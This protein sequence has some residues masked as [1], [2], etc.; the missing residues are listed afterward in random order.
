[1]PLA[2]KTLAWF[3]IS[4]QINPENKDLPFE[5]PLS[6]HKTRQ[7]AWALLTEL[8][9]RYF[10]GSAPHPHFNG[11][12]EIAMMKALQYVRLNLYDP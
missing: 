3:Y 12:K 9:N 10:K 5:H 4:E 7:N 11:N 6:Q 1:M 2:L 8:E